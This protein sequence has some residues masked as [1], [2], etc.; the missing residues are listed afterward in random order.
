MFDSQRAPSQ[1][2]R[3][4]S[5]KQSP[6]QSRLPTNPLMEDCEPLTCSRYEAKA[7]QFKPR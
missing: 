1:S 2:T 3:R 7:Q 4:R 6:L 5:P